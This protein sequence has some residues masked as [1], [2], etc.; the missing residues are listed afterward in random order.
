MCLYYAIEIKKS[1]NSHVSLLR[2]KYYKISDNKIL[3][4]KLVIYYIVLEDIGKHNTI[5]MFS[6]SYTCANK[7]NKT[8][9]L[10]HLFH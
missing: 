9:C 3:H 1:P 6:K 2:Y 7:N 4:K 5:H 8:G 10:Q